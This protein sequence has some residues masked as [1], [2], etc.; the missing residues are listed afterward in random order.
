MVAFVAGW[1]GVLWIG[2]LLPR[3][4]GVCALLGKLS[5]VENDY[6]RC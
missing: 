6:A 3:A 1:N 2:I 5:M 4:W